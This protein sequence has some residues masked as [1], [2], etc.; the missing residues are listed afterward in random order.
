[1]GPARPY[2]LDA[3]GLG[4]N[5]KSKWADN[6]QE[7]TNHGV[8]PTSPGTYSTKP[9]GEVPKIVAEKVLAHLDGSTPGAAASSRSAP[10]GQ[11]DDGTDEKTKRT[12]K[13]SCRKSRISETAVS[14]RAENGKN[15]IEP[16][17]NH[18]WKKQIREWLPWICADDWSRSMFASAFATPTTTRKPEE[19]R[20]L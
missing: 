1:M 9:S 15:T 17:V 3:L 16:R 12:K 10:E 18:V 20:A 5:F 4:N 11:N 19:P 7:A 13:S 2:G 6:A 14:P 8:V